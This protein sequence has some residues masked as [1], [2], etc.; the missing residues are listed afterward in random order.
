MAADVHLDSGV[1]VISGLIDHASVPSL[2]DKVRA[3]GKVR[4]EAIDSAG[5]KRIDSA[6]IAFLV[7]CKKQLCG[8]MGLI[9]IRN[10]P[11][12]LS[13][14]LLVMGLGDLFAGAD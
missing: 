2:M 8:D 13:R 12:Q 5:L 14:L 6:G 7:W 4:V 3:L 10:A 11:E 9:E 1:L